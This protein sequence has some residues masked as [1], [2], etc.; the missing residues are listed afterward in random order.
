MLELDGFN[1]WKIVYYFA[2]K[3]VTKIALKE[4]GCQIYIFDSHLVWLMQLKII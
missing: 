1:K 3:M 2:A 4:Y